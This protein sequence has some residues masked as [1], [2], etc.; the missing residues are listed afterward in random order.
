MYS[1][2]PKQPTTQPSGDMGPGIVAVS[3]LR[4]HL[5]AKWDGDAKSGRLAYQLRIEPM[6]ERWGPGFSRVTLNPPMPISVN[7]RLLDASGFALCGKEVDLRFS[8][9]TAAVPAGLQTGPNGKKLSPAE[10]VAVEQSARQTAISQMQAAESQREQGKDIFQNQ[11]TTDGQVTALNAQGTLP[12]SPDQFKRADY[13]DFNT[14]F[15]TL[16]DQAALLDPRLATAQHKELEPPAHPERRTVSKLAQQGYII[17]GDDRVT[18]YDPIHGLLLAEE[19]KAFLIDKR[20][21][22]STASAW[23][24]NYSLIH[25]KCDQHANCSLS[26]P[27]G[28]SVLRARLN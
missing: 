23:A 8:P 11:T 4:G 3:G 10:R 28:L 20:T 18:G 22:R 15:P 2:K 12:C 27:G 6:E 7:V 13:W 25:Y 9:Q 17:Q 5:D 21:G 26:S 14:N 1:A 19:G 24:S 16:A